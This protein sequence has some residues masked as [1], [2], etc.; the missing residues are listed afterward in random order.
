MIARAIHTPGILEEDRVAI[1]E[2]ANTL[3]ITGVER[4]PHNKN[5][6]SAY[7]ELGIE[8]YKRTGS[9]SFYNEAIKQLKIAEERLGDPDV[10]SI[11]ARYERRLAGQ[12]YEPD[13]IVI[14]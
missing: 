14:D 2:Q 8:Y 9:Y 5:I 13:S 11:I 10:S 6:L 7:A 4:Y 1:L 3:A 12:T